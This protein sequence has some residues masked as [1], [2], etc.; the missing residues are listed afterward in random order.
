[1]IRELKM[2]LINKTED[3][4]R[5][6]LHEKRKKNYQNFEQNN[7]F[8]FYSNLFFACDSKC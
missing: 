4:R 7:V 3:T 8:F 5:K 2:Y 6:Y 1:M